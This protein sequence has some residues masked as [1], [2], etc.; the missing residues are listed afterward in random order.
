MPNSGVVTSYDDNFVAH[1]NLW[2]TASQ[3]LGAELQGVPEMP[4][5]EDANSLVGV[6]FE[7][8]PRVKRFRVT[9]KK[10]T[11]V[12]SSPWSGGFTFAAGNALFP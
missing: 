1:Y 7:A 8:E 9:T 11:V 12:V 3:Q 6:V 10:A 2:G 5:A 4:V